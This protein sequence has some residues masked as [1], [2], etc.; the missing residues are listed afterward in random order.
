MTTALVKPVNLTLEPVLRESGWHAYRLQTGAFPLAEENRRRVG[1]L[2]EGLTTALTTVCGLVPT[3]WVDSQ[4]LHHD[5]GT[6]IFSANARAWAPTMGFCFDP[7]GESPRPLAMS[8]LM[9]VDYGTPPKIHDRSAIHI[10]AH[11]QTMPAYRLLAGRGIS[12]LLYFP[13]ST[14]EDSGLMHAV[15]AFIEHS[16]DALRPLIRSG[17]FQNF[18]FY[19]PLLSSQSIVQIPAQQLTSWM[20]GVEVYLHESF[21]AEEMLILSRQDLNLVF[22]AAH[23]RPALTDEI[24][25]PWTLLLPSDEEPSRA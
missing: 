12:V 24:N 15:E 1:F 5:G 25:V 21:D 4:P 19:L 22:R 20:G 14:P 6:K 2:V 16:R 9:D 8:D 23:L 3:L 18:P 17:H 11:A 7:S 13:A 10:S